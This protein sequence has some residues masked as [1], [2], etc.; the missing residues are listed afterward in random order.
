MELRHLRYFVAV[1]ESLHF[2]QAAAKLEIAQPSLS[3]QVRQLETELQTTLLRRTKRS[4]ELTD[5]GRLFLEQAR[6]I[7]A[8]ADRAAMIARRVGRGESGRL[9]IGVGYCMDQSDIGKAVSA[10]NRRHPTVHVQLRTIAVPAQLEALRTERL[11]I[12]VVRPPVAEPALS[13]E[14]LVAEPLVV[15]LPKSHRLAGRRGITLSALA[16]EAFILPPRDSV[17]VYHDLVLKACRE[18]G[19]VPDVPHEA[20]HLPMVLGMVAAGSGVSLIPAFARRM[21]PPRVVFV[22]LRPAPPSLETAVAWR[23]EN[24]S[25]MLTEFVQIARGVLVRAR[26]RLAA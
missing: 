16:E 18:A 21:R 10:F 14:I 13:H 6:D 12:G 24:T 11:D 1:S 8:R 2:G 23:R 7:L 20:D 4:V 19:F 25:P 26:K 9:R 5:A 22:S 15:A 3:H 17:P